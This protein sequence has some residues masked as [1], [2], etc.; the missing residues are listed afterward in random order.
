MDGSQESGYLPTASQPKKRNWLQH[1]R[2]RA[3]GQR[4][5]KSRLAAAILTV[6]VFAGIGVPAAVSTPAQAATTGTGIADATRYGGYAGSYT[7]ND[8]DTYCGDPSRAWPSGNTGGGSTI[9]SFIS[10]SGYTLSGTAMSGINAAY[11]AY[12][13]GSAVDRAAFNMLVYA[14][15]GSNIGG[16]VQRGTKAEGAWYISTSHPEITVKYNE[17]WDYAQTHQNTGGGGTDT[18]NYTFNVD[19]NN[20]TGTMTAHIGAAGGVAATTT[21]TNGI[22]TATGTNTIQNLTDGATASVRGVPPAD[23]TSYEIS[24]TGTVK[25]PGGAAAELR[26]YNTGTE[27][28]LLAGTGTTTTHSYPISGHDPFNRS[29]LFAPTVGTTVVNEFAPG[30]QKPQDT[31]TFTTTSYTDDSGHTI[32]N[33]WAQRSGNSAYAVVSARGTLYGPSAAPFTP[34]DTVP[35]GTPVA[36]HAT[37]TTTDTD[38]PTVPYTATSDTAVAES[39]YYTWV[40]T[41]EYADQSVGTQ[42]QLPAGY[43]FTDGFGLVAETSVSPSQVS[44]STKLS[45]QRVGLDGTVTDTITP[46]LAGGAWLQKDGARIPVTLTGRVYYSPDKPVQATTP[47]AGARLTDTLHA[48]LTGPTPVTTTPYKMG[49]TPGWK[50]VQWSIEKAVQ[51][52][53]YQGYVADWSDDWGVAAETVQITAPAITTNAV[54]T[55]GP[56][57]P[58]HDTVKA[59]GLMPARGLDVK[60][61]AYLQK[62]ATQP[63]CDNTTRVF[64]SS[65][66]HLDTPGSV[67]SDVYTI[68]ENTPYGAVINWVDTTTLTGTDQ[69][70]H[71]GVCGDPS[72]QTTLTPP[73]VTSTPPTSTLEGGTAKDTLHVTGWVP[74]G[75]VTTVTVYKQ[76][77]NTA[78]LACTSENLFE[79]LTAT[80]VKAGPA[81]KANYSTASTKP[82][83]AGHY[84]FVHTTRD[85][86]GTVITQGACTDEPFTVT[87]ALPHTGNTINLLSA[88]LA[89]GLITLGAATTYVRRRK[90]TQRKR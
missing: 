19:Q 75:T 28:R 42:H 88:G 45:A 6:G 60:F 43:S 36:G 16:G 17:V 84:A 68:P 30:G 71:T 64:T 51:P 53:E 58:V 67:D 63:V 11:G 25:V 77:A 89:T 44:F 1:H 85:Q 32:N 87:P 73:A 40:W 15:T 23:A 22:F 72:E 4:R 65:P 82:L 41:I 74:A 20:Y 24:A 57:A 7:V 35:A 5:Q 54:T 33:P 90:T 48:V 76:P 56:G 38:G 37:V 34:S 49:T 79:T 2:H 52:A 27:Q 10:D 9:T 21:L 83:P 69:V 12:G 13:H 61:D 29:T 78:Q 62:L 70:L 81:D 3:P 14:Y 39:G 47:P 8:V 66:V 18:G 86:N 80:H 50:T 46:A 31:L 55:A 59:S 26:Q